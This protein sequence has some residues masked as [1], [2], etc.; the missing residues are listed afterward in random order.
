MT[1]PADLPARLEARATGVPGLQYVILGPEGRRR[2]YASGWA[3]IQGGI[4]MTS[5]TTLMA[6][7][8]TKTFS[9]V[10]ILQLIECRQ[11]HLDDEM[12]RYLPET[13]YRG[14]RISIRHL[15]THTAGLPNP[16]P[17]RWVHLVEEAD[18][19]NE[20]E[21]LARILRKHPHLVAPPGREYG[22]SNI[23]YWLLGRI[24]E[25]VADEPYVD[26][27]RSHVLAPLGLPVGE[28][29]FSISAPRHHAKG[30]LARLSLMNLL[31]GLVTDRKFWGD[32]E[33]RWLHLRNHYL[34]GPA[35]GG[36]VGTA[37]AFARFLRDQLSPASVL[38]GPDARQLL[39][40][41]QNTAAGVPIPM[42]LGW[43][44]GG[45]GESTYLFKEGGGGGFHSEMR[46]YRRQGIA[47]VVLANS[48]GFRSTR[49]LDEVDAI[50]LRDSSLLGAR[51]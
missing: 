23:G 35:F 49:F 40:A 44:I 15:L 50:F 16:I 32:Y 29:G 3:D 8:M 51:D 21:A 36:L 7:S 48:T 24:I 25:R 33:G 4:A 46:L 30:Y 20:G 22:Y 9:A 19:F 1:L 13:P 14:R 37:N 39:E 12:D 27:M 6:Y 2:E 47:S 38:L 41:R 18:V 43:H 26:Y 31:K 10:G 34:D 17:L 42:T 11:L 28:L 45:N 5:A